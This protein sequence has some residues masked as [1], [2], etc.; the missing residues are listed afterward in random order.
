MAAA[1]LDRRNWIFLA[2]LVPA[3][4]L[5]LVWA[6]LPD[7]QPGE[8]VQ[9][10]PV[11]AKPAPAAAEPSR[12]DARQGSNP[13]DSAPKAKPFHRK[14]DF[15]VK[16][17]LQLDGPLGPG[18]YVWDDSGVPAGQVAIVV[19]IKNELIH[20][21]RGGDEIGRSTVIYGD[22]EKPTPIGVFP[23]MEKKADYYSKT[24]GGAP[25]PHMLRLTADGV[26]IHGSRQ[27]HPDYATHGCV[28]LPKKFAAIL[29]REAK[30]GDYVKITR[31][32]NPAG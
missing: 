24:Y 29:F 11:A 5:A 30:V 26:A 3:G 25:M 13:Q 28:G 9:S 4:V 32:W 17:M 6:V 15:T 2:A 31:G 1:V 22:D 7:R 20:V 23:I 21:Y 8:P 10:R 14:P 12:P 19:D 18:D 27:I 16:T